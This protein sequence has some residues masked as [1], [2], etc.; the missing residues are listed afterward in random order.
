MFFPQRSLGSWKLISLGLLW[1]LSGV[2]CLSFVE[3]ADL[4]WGEGG[5]QESRLLPPDMPPFFM[6]TGISRGS[7]LRL[8]REPNLRSAVVA[9]IPFNARGIRNLGCQEGIPSRQRWCLVEYKGMT[10]WAFGGYLKEDPSPP[11]MLQGAEAERMLF[12]GRWNFISGPAGAVEGQ[13]WLRFYAQDATRGFVLGK[14]GCNI[15]RA[16]FT[17][18]G[19]AGLRLS[20]FSVSDLLCGE[21]TEAQEESFQDLIGPLIRFEIIEKT[22]SLQI[23]GIKR[24][25]GFALQKGL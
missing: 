7:S 10:G 6:V 1:L 18:Q 12:A 9:H 3:A 13:A 15:M 16:R 14:M 20:E 21:E 25:Y 19:T 24:P 2:L 8:R 4:P 22:L 17:S 5:V 11:V 23:D